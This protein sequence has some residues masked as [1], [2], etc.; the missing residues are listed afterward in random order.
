[1]S[2]LRSG[3]YNLAGALLPA[4][5]L[6]VTIPVIVHRLGAEAYGALV[7]ITSIVGYF[8]I[9]DV[10][11]HAGTVKYVAE[12][13]ARTEDDRVAQVVTTG[14]LLHAA[15]GLTGAC[16][17]W[18]LAPW[19]VDVV[20]RFDLGWRAEALAALR[21]SAVAFVVG[22]LQ[23]W[24][25]SLPQ[26]LQ[27]YDITG[28]L[29]A[30]FG[31]LIPLATLVAVLAGGALVA[32]VV[33]RLVLSGLHA[34]LLARAVSALLPA[35]RP[36]R[37]DGV[38][39]RALAAFSTWSWLQ[40]LAALT[41]ANADKLLIG[42]QQSVLALAAY[43]IP[44]TL[45]SRVF[46]LL[47]RLQQAVFPL[48]SAL[49]ASGNLAALKG[50]SVRLQRCTLY[51]N[52]ALCLLCAL[53]AKELLHY[54]LH[55]QPS[56]ASAL[57]LVLVSYTLMADSL[58][59]VPSLVN[60]GLGRP[61]LTATAALLR[62]GIGLAAAAAALTWGDIVWLAASQLLV[63][64]AMALGFLRVVHRRSLPW[65]LGEVARPVYALNAA[66]L[67]VG[68]A[69]LLWRWHGPV[70]DPLAFALALGVASALLAVV[71]WRL[72]LQGDER[73]RLGAAWRGVLG[74]R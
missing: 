7:L 30:L 16:L 39:V 48:S 17:L 37:P 35:L 38:T 50:S 62:A 9:L 60:D 33:V 6:F 1:M 46:G 18:V 52:V 28:R 29:D 57:V 42:A 31:T 49:A 2:L 3:V 24:L 56:D 34:L 43:V 12:H 41:T 53:F 64:V 14:A 54:W 70:L 23:Q 61:R 11:A 22:Q 20:F 67:A 69:L 65:T 66:V 59:H 63:S 58:T 10:N 26:A 21:W 68:T 72:V 25:Q 5:V 4:V 44:Y 19:L 47:Y 51:L 15:L 71:G 32:I 27:R 13:H 74:T 45:C 73:Q 8:G 40:R 36:A 55:G